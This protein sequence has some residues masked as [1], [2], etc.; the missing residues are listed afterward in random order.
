M[1][2]QLIPVSSLMLYLGSILTVACHFIEKATCHS[3]LFFGTA[4]QKYIWILLCTGSCIGDS[5][6]IQLLI[7]GLFTICHILINGW[8]RCWCQLR[9]IIKGIL[10]SISEITG[11][12][13]SIRRCIINALFCIFLSICFLTLSI[14]CSF[15][16]FRLSVH[17]SSICKSIQQQR[18]EC[19]SQIITVH[20]CCRR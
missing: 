14:L 17:L 3:N 7:K 19:Y 9:R 2:F 13:I 8:R 12:R 15:N 11:R 18:T 4:A 20:I 10:C 6:T 16:S 1:K 5:L